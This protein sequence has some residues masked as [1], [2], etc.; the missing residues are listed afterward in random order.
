MAIQLC[1]IQTAEG[2]GLHF[3]KVHKVQQLG[4]VDED[5]EVAEATNRDYLLK[6]GTPR[7][8]AIADKLLSYI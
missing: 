3:T 6:R 4:L 5:E 7:T 8:V 1:A 2:V